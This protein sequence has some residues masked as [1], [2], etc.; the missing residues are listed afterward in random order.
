MADF[1]WGAVVLV[2]LYH[3]SVVFMLMWKGGRGMDRSHITPESCCFLARVS[4]G[5][6]SR[7]EFLL[8]RRLRPSLLPGAQ[9]SVL[10]VL[11]WVWSW[12][13]FLCCGRR[14]GASVGYMM[15]RRPRWLHLNE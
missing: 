6:F 3:G 7:H 2:L 9:H 14:V 13:P 11:V 8:R 12:L 15:F 4:C 10:Y 5:S 1:G